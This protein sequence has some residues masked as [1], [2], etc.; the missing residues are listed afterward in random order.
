M[1]EPVLPTEVVGFLDPGPGKRYVDAT[2]GAGGHTAALLA[3]GAFVVGVDQDPYALALARERLSPFGD[4]VTLVRGN[5]RDLRALL[6]PLGLPAL[7]GILLDLGASSLQFDA[8]DRGFSF[9]AEGPLDMRMDPDA[10][11]TA[12]DLVNGLPE[13]DL[14][15]LLWEY[16]EERYGRRIARAIVRARPLHTTGELAS[17]VSRAYP[18]G[19]HRIHPATRTFQALRIAVNDELGALRE[20]LPAAVS[21]LASGGVLCVISFHSLEDRIVK[22]FLREGALAGRLEVLTKK[23]ITP[24]EEELA[25]NPRAR[26]AKL[27]AARVSE[28]GLPPASCPRS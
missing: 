13:P 21:L 19:R 14:A 4:R 20:A 1:H 18:P 27:R 24:A 26:S 10:P 25:R 17:L 2:V 28:V 11:T 6:A 5:F 12:A 3:R 23:P 15:R 22:H 8:P 16:G 7:D 9:R